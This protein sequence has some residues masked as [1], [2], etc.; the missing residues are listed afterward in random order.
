MD[1]ADAPDMA[2][3][4]RVTLLDEDDH[5]A[6][7]YVPAENLA[8]LLEAVRRLR[9]RGRGPPDIATDPARW[10]ALRE[11]AFDAARQPAARAGAALCGLWCSLY[12]P[13][14]PEVR[15]RL[16]AVMAEHGKAAV[17]LRRHRPSRG[18]ATLVGEAADARTLEL[19]ARMAAE[20]GRVPGRIVAVL[21][22][23]EQDRV[24]H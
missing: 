4:V 23:E 2:G 17:V 12:G 18:V 8:D 22:D 20:A 3:H 1:A 14:G 7:A 9:H 19:A 15:R 5:G 24:E 10:S 13:M 6:T 11:G 16:S 21:P